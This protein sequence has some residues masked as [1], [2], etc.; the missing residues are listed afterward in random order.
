M[1]IKKTP[2]GKESKR[3]KRNYA[4]NITKFYTGI[5]DIFKGSAAIVKWD[6]MPRLCSSTY[7][8]RQL[9]SGVVYAYSLDLYTAPYLVTAHLADQFIAVAPCYITVHL[10][11]IF[12]VL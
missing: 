11:L 9:Y 10:T 12:Q 5:F 8:L 4:D 7:R 6:P 2:E 3:D 1:A